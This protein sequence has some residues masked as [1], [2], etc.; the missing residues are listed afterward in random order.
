MTQPSVTHWDSPRADAEPPRRRRWTLRSRLVLGIVALLAAASIVVGLVSVVALRGFLMDRLDDQLLAATGRTQPTSE[1]LPPGGAL[2]YP[3][4]P[5]FGVQGPGTMVALT[6]GD[7][8]RAGV[9]TSDGTLDLLDDAHA[10]VL[11]G[12]TEG[13]GPVTVDLG[14]E[15]GEYRVVARELA[16][17]ILQ[18]TGLSQSEVNG[19]VAQLLLV[20]GVVAL[21]ALA[22]AAAA[23]LVVVRLALRPLD[24]VAATAAQVSELPLDRGEVALAVRVSDDDADPSTE[25]GRVGAAINRMLG[26]V[27]SA[28]AARQASENKVRRFVADASH[29]LR[30]P[31][32]SIRGYAELT[33]RGGYELPDDVVRSIGR[34]ESEAV[35]MTSLVEDLLLLA[36]LD[37]GRDLERAPLELVGLLADAVG[38]AH[39]AGPDHE[40]SLEAPEGPVIVNGDVN[41]LHQVVANLLANARVHT[42][43]GTAVVVELSERADGV[44]IVVRDDGPGI[45]EKLLPE[46]FERFVRGDSSRSR[47]AGSTGLGLAIVRAVVEGHGGTVS[48]ASEPGRTEFRVTLPR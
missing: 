22:A 25:V 30:T 3:S 16:P 41:R 43:E 11:I 33:R 26:H 24:R 37:E 18:V 35:R 27:A 5:S 10:A 40:W 19:T 23:G 21:V 1:E 9:L 2:G 4:R 12:I 8:A 36:R 6:S 7:V 31:L 34:V 45:P 42:P 13:D 32:A 48:V 17:G 44:D 39:A 20:I 29:E 14:G 47:V 38:D 46:L 28:L 15:L